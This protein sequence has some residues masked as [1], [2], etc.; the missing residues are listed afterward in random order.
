MSIR[1]CSLVYGGRVRVMSEP[2]HERAFNHLLALS[3]VTVNFARVHRAPRYPGGARESDVEHS[4]H[5]ALSAMELAPMY[6]EDLDTGLVVQFCLVHDLPEV[7]VGDVWTFAISDEDRALKEENER[8]ATERLLATLPPVT[9]GLL[10]R[11]EEQLEP[12]ARFTRYIDK[13]LPAMI[14][15]VAGESSTFLSDY[16]VSTA[17]ELAEARRGHM[18]KLRQMFPEFEEL[19]DLAQY[20]HE[21]SARHV[22]GDVSYTHRFTQD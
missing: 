14:N 9:A 6:R 4:Y 13:L 1:L 17:E 16:G 21:T 5:L 15:I 8:I 20:A 12:E 10:K 22:L 7:H 11:Y 3:D 19:H 18:F 2:K